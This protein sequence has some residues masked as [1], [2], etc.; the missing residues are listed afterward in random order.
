M[1]FLV[2]FSVNF[3]IS[4][5]ILSIPI[6]EKTIFDHLYQLTKSEASKKLKVLKKKSKLFF[7][8]K[9][10]LRKNINQEEAL[11]KFSTTHK[12]HSLSSQ[13]KK[14]ID[15]SY[16]DEEREAMRR[17]LENHQEKGY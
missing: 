7:Y 3:C 15:D 8:G 9:G 16:T 11:S 2:R 14:I 12:S 6:N 17:I 5:V 4:F 13:A 1:M 10:K